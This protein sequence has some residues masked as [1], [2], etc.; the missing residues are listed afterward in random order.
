VLAGSTG[1]AESLRRLVSAVP[2]VRARRRPGPE[3]DIA[4]PFR[5]P[6]EAHREAVRAI[7]EAIARLAPALR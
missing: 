3:D 7:S 1:P 5:K 6:A 4:D 2:R